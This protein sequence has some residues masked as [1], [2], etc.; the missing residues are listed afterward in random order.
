MTKI[1]MISSLL[2]CLMA[3]NLVNK[4]ENIFFYN[5]MNNTFACDTIYDSSVKGGKRVLNIY[6]RADAK[7]VWFQ[8]RNYY[9]YKLSTDPDDVWML[10]NFREHK[11]FTI[12]EGAINQP[13]KY[14]EE[15]LLDLNAKIGSTWELGQGG[16][17]G[18]SLFKLDSVVEDIYYIS[19][20]P[21]RKIADMDQVTEFVISKTAGVKSLTLVSLGD[22][23]ACQ[24]NNK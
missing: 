2:L 3:C 15:M 10:L 5:A 4:H 21:R 12:P 22:T 9:R 13:A 24:C 11:I 19:A 17:L 20:K 16:D 1:L 8:E 6:E 18:N 23:I 14:N 7:P